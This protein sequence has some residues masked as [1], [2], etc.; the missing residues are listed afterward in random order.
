MLNKKEKDELQS[1][2]NKLCNFLNQKPP[3]GELPFTG[4]A[5]EQE[6]KKDSFNHFTK[7]SRDFHH[8]ASAFFGY[9]KLIVIEGNEPLRKLCFDLKIS[10]MPSMI[11]KFK[12][13]GLADYTTNGKEF[14]PKMISFT[15]LKPE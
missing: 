10:D 12:E 4:T 2:I 5:N 1:I 3:P 9:N 13:R 6:K 14:K 15:L 7:P 11:K 8:A